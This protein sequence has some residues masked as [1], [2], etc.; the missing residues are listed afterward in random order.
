MRW[1]WGLLVGVAL[2]VATDAEQRTLC[3]QS[4][5]QRAA[6]NSLEPELLYSGRFFGGKSWML[7]AK[8][9]IYAAVYPGARVGI[10]REERASMDATTLATMRDEIMPRQVWDVCWRESKSTIFLPNNS[11]IRFFGLDKPGRMLGSRYGFVGIDQAE[12]LDQ[13]QFELVNSR[14]TQVGMPWHQTALAVNPEGDDHWIYR[15]YR[16]DKGDGLRQDAKGNPFAQVLL[17]QPDDLISYLSEGSVARLDRMEGVWRQRYRLGQWC[18]FEGAVFSSW[19]PSVRVI[20]TP[21]EWVIWNGYP[22]PDWPRYRGM[23]F[24]YDDPF[25]FQWWAKQP[26]VERYFRYREIYKTGVTVE[27]H[28]ARIMELEAAELA[29]LRDAAK[30]L[31]A[32][33]DL[34]PYLESLNVEATW[35]D[36]HRGERES[37]AEHGVSSSPAIKDILAGIQTLLGLMDPREPE[38]GIFLVK[39]ALDEYDTRLAESNRPTCTEEEISGYRWRTKAGG[40][41]TAQRPELPIDRNNH[42]IDAMRYVFHSQGRQAE[43]WF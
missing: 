4:G 42:G 39:G 29:A 23:D 33:A 27:Y 13:N 15:R 35:S 20:D 1:W 25:V 31:G 2:A 16:P 3:G 21:A 41:M 36:H 38:R 43:I 14:V 28:A 7:C 24:G 40:D 8:G 12:Q 11:E 5:A 18:S 9:F 17:V 19:D 37:M 6:L 10:C 22:P 32:E 26:G 34:A 30:R